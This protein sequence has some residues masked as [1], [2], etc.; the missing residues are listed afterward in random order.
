MDAVDA[1]RKI[2]DDRRARWRRYREARGMA[3]DAPFAGR[4]PL[5]EAYEEAL[6][7]MNYLEEM[8][9]RLRDAGPEASVAYGRCAR[10]AYHAYNAARMCLMAMEALPED[11]LV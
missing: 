3:E 9:R 5:V 6:D 4:H 11:G 10:A 7:M 8:E 2:E 1:Y